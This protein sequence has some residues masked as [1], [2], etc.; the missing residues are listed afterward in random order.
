MASNPRKAKRVLAEAAPHVGGAVVVIG[1]GRGD[2][3]YLATSHS[4]NS[5]LEIDAT[6]AL[7]SQ[8]LKKLRRWRQ[9]MPAPP[10]P[11]PP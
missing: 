7:V 2:S 8:A 1:E 10:A 3:E 4:V 6:I 5:A 9:R 11:P